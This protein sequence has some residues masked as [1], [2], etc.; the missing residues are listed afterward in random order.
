[1]VAGSKIVT[2]AVGEERVPTHAWRI[3][4]VRWVL[5]G[6]DNRGWSLW[7]AWVKGVS[8]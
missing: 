2:V 1:M 6:L 3:E 8:E 7:F 4:W 5:G